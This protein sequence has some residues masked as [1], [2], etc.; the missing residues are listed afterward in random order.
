MNPETALMIKD[1]EAFGVFEEWLYIPALE[2]GGCQGVFEKLIWSIGLEDRELQ[3]LYNFF[4]LVDFLQVSDL[5]RSLLNTLMFKQRKIRIVLI[6]LLLDVYQNILPGSF[7]R[8][9]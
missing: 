2:A 1:I 3:L 5:R 7:L 8:K 6:L 4:L 9:I